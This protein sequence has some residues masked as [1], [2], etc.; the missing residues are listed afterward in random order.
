MDSDPGTPD[1]SVTDGELEGSVAHSP[2]SVTNARVRDRSSPDP[3]ARPA[4]KSG[5]KIGKRACHSPLSLS[6]Y[7]HASLFSVLYASTDWLWSVCAWLPIARVIRLEGV[8]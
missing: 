6:A 2:S 4:G 8:D 5:P 3:N 1:T 7:T